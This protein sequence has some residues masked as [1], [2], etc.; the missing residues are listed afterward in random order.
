MVM[1]SIDVEETTTTTADTLPACTTTT[2]TL[3]PIEE[4]GIRSGVDLGRL[5]HLRARTAA[6]ETHTIA[7]EDAGVILSDLGGTK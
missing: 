2:Q 7:L 4:T 3:S 6:V 5:C 1:R